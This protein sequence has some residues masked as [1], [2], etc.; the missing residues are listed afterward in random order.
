MKSLW[1]LA[2]LL[3]AGCTDAAGV[4]DDDSPGGSGKA[5]DPSAEGAAKA[6]ARVVATLSKYAPISRI[7]TA[8]DGRVCAAGSFMVTMD[9]GDGVPV[10]PGVSPDGYVVCW[11][12][13]GHYLWHRTYAGEQPRSVTELLVAPDGTVYVAGRIMVDRP[14][15]SPDDDDLFV[16]RLGATGEFGWYHAI[17]TYAMDYPTDLRLSPA[18]DVMVSGR[19]GGIIDDCDLTADVWI[20][21]KMAFTERCDSFRRDLTFLATV[22]EPTGAMDTRVFKQ[23]PTTSLPRLLVGAFHSTSADGQ[24]LA[25]S[26]TSTSLVEPDWSQATRPMSPQVDVVTELEPIGSADRFLIMGTGGNLTFRVIS[27]DA[28]TT[29]TFAEFGNRQVALP[30]MLSVGP[31]ILGWATCAEGF[32]VNGQVHEPTGGAADAC[33]VVLSDAGDVREVR[34]LGGGAFDSAGAIHQSAS[35]LY[36][37]AS[38]TGMVTMG[39]LSFDAGDGQQLVLDLPLPNP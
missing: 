15:P 6:P 8:A 30:G 23:Y 4:T 35:R 5:D 16:A 24:I 3:F 17:G 29:R 34:R 19:V 18:G 32:T 31:S 9:F 27:Y 13:Q 22:D 12:A 2:S 28:G 7:G 39:N 38:L 25:V 11:D 1:I 37:T 14:P 36:L 20:P 10:S 26:G 21:H 33:L